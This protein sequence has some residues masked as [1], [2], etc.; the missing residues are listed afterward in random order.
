[1]H[2]AKSALAVAI[3]L[4]LATPAAAQSPVTLAADETTALTT[5]MTATVLIY[6]PTDPKEGALNVADSLW[7]TIELSRDLP[8]EKVAD[9]LAARIAQ[10]DTANLDAIRADPQRYMTICN[11]RFPISRRENPIKLAP[12]GFKRDTVCLSI[13]A[14][15]K[16]IYDGANVPEFSQLA[17]RVIAKN[18]TR[19]TDA[20][21]T[22]NGY[23]TEAKVSRLLG[24]SIIEA[25]KFG[26]IHSVLVA[27]D[28]AG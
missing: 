23:N 13:A 21:F 3:G 7:Y 10:V 19:L 5:C 8:G 27:C 9:A 18:L 11:E 28:A 16:G 15:L 20:T 12:A 25:H 6:N 22:R 24:N 26:H 1:M 14:L 4:A 17:D 2:I